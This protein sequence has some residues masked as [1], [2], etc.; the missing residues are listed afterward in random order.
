MAASEALQDVYRVVETD[1]GSFGVG[2][3]YLFAEEYAGFAE[4]RD[5]RVHTGAGLDENDDGN[6]IAADL[7]VGDFLR[8]AVVCD[9]EI[10]LLEIVNHGAVRIALGDWR[11]DEGD[12]CGDFCESF[13]RSGLNFGSWLGLHGAFGSLGEERA[14]GE[15]GE[16]NG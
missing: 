10:L 12:A 11:I 3:H 7:K 14:G 1:D 15:R 5:K 16:E 8:D 9:D 4:L 13:G 6:G 2:T